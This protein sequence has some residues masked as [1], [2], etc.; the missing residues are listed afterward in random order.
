MVA[1]SLPAARA[2]QTTRIAIRAGSVVLPLENPLRVVEER[3]MN[4]NFP[5]GRV[6][7]ATSSG[8]Q[9]N[10]FVL[11]PHTYQNRYHD[12]FRKIALIQKLWR[13]ETVSL[14]N[15]AEILTEVGILPVPIQKEPALWLTGQSDHSFLHAGRLG[16]S[17]LTAD[18]ALP[19]DFSE[20]TRR[21]KNPS[22][23]ISSPP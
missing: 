15:G 23:R 22:R 1:L 20:F 13:G 18:F 4:E 12:M 14:L 8:W 9:V 2:V 16:C 19:H 5:N 3:A 11:S 17:V 6:A 21:S 10:G 7:I